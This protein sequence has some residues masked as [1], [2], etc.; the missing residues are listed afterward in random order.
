MTDPLA[1]RFPNLFYDIEMVE[2]RNPKPVPS[3]VQVVTAILQANGMSNNAPSAA[4]DVVTA[5]SQYNARS[6]PTKG[7]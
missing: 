2:Q 4:I 5:I 1:D 3:L 7:A 6:V